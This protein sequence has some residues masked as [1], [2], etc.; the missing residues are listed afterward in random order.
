MQNG[1]RTEPN[2]GAI[3]RTDAEINSGDFRGKRDLDEII[4]GFRRSELIL[5]GARSLVGM[6]SLAFSIVS[7]VAIDN[8]KPIAYFSLELSGTTLTQRLTAIQSRIEL[9]QLGAGNLTVSEMKRFAE[10]ASRVYHA[11]IYVEDSSDLRVDELQ[12]KV[13]DLK[14]IHGIECVF[15]DYLNLLKPNI[16]K[17]TKTRIEELSEIA[18]SLKELAV[19]SNL[20]V[21]TLIQ[22]PRDSRIKRPCLSDLG[23]VEPQDTRVDV[24]ILINREEGTGKSDPQDAQ[25][26]LIVA[27]NTS[28]CLGTVRVILE[29]W[30]RPS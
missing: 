8:G 25:A 6:R 29:P 28:G 13:R 17:E 7:Q 30:C 18:T 10:E 27:K 16:M 23:F 22:L 19:D 1:P 12:G 5:V 11:P 24:V 20:T 14:E 26:E 9:S 2:G 3:T 4:Q 15:I 21:V